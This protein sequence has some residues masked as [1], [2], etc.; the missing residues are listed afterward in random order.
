[1]CVSVNGRMLDGEVELLG[2]F[3]DAVEN[4]LVKSKSVSCFGFQSFRGGEELGCLIFEV[5]IAL[6]F[7]QGLG[8]AGEVA[9]IVGEDLLRVSFEIFIQKGFGRERVSLGTLEWVRNLDSVL[10]KL[11]AVEALFAI[12]LIKGVGILG[13]ER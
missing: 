2:H 5:D 13:D 6:L 8:F 7:F 4:A 12:V 10:E 9:E 1:M 11:E 3:L